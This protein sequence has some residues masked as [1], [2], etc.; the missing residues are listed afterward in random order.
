[1]A[2]PKA[3]KSYFLTSRFIIISPYYILLFIFFIEYDY[4]NHRVKHNKSYLLL[5]EVDN[6]LFLVYNF[7]KFKE[8]GVITYVV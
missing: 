4:T 8:K 7:I 5:Y 1:M 2:W 3:L 6:K